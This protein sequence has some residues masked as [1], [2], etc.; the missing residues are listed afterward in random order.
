MHVD[1]SGFSPVSFGV[2]RVHS[3]LFPPLTQNCQGASLFSRWTVQRLHSAFPWDCKWAL[4]MSLWQGCCW[5]CCCYWWMRT[6]LLCHSGA[7]TYLHTFQGASCMC[8]LSHCI[9]L[10]A[11]PAQEM[12]G[13]LYTHGNCCILV[14]VRT[15]IIE[16]ESHT[17]QCFPINYLDC[18]GPSYAN[19]SRE[20]FHY[21]LTSLIWWVYNGP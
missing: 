1:H 3:G 7:K 14:F 11:P 13:Y 9:C 5:C 6:H 18:G 2:I 8:G 16:W 20:S 15:K 12:M 19:F 17:I 10:P 4:F 21:K